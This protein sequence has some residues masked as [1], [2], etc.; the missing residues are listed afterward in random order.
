[1]AGPAPSPIPMTAATA[2]RT[3]RGVM[4]SAI[5]WA[6]VPTTP[7]R[8]PINLAVSARP[9]QPRARHSAADASDAAALSTVI[10]TVYL[11]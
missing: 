8:R 6:H 2:V 7:G 1:M 5:W 11:C 9:I 3:N 4:L 10:G